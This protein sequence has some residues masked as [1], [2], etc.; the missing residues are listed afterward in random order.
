MSPKVV[1]TCDARGGGRKEKQEGEGE[2][3]ERLNE[4]SGFR[5]YLH[6]LV[7]AALTAVCIF[8]QTMH[9]VAM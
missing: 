8:A 6:Q 7:P 1:S 9:G 2:E 4:A 5:A 3:E